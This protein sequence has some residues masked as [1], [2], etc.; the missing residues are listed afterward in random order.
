MMTESKTDD[1]GAKKPRRRWTLVK[2][3]S[4]IA[5]VGWIATAG[6]VA[7]KIYV[8]SLNSYLNVALVRSHTERHALSLELERISAELKSVQSRL[9]RY[10]NQDAQATAN[11]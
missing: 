6:L 10:Q 2:A 1:K 9:E 11:P 5:A 8:K 7:E 3:V 4:L